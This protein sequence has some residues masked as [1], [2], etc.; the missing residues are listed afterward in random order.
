MRSLT[1]T[2]DTQTGDDGMAPATVTITENADGTLS[3]TITNLETPDDGQ[4]ADIRAL[5]FDVSDDALLGTMSATSSEVIISDFDDDGD[6]DNLGG[7]ATASG[8]PDSPYEVG[9]EF[10]TSGSAT[11]DYQTVSFTLDSSLRDL[12]LDDI[13]LETFVVRQTSVTSDS[14]GGREDSDK[15]YGDAPYP[16]NAIDDAEELDEDTTASGNV[17]ANDIDED[18]GDADNDGIPDGLTVTAIDG[19]S[20]AV[21]STITL[22][23]GITLVVNADG[24]Y[25]V[26]ANDAD[27]LSAGESVEFSVDYSVD[28]GNG[29]S[30]TATLT[31]TVN[32]VNDV[33]VVNSADGLG[34]VVEDDADPTLTDSG[35]IEFGDVDLLD[36]HTA[37]SSFDSTTHS[38]QLGSLTATLTGDTTG[39]GTGGEVT[40]DY[41]VSNAAVQFMAVGETITESY[42]VTISDGNGSTVTETVDVTITG[43]NDDVVITSADTSGAVVEDAADPV[44]SDGGTMSFA[45][46]DLSDGHDVTASFTSTDNVGGELGTFSVSETAD[47]TGTGTG[48]ALSWSFT[49]DNADVQFLGAGEVV[50]QTYTV[51]VTDNNGSTDTEVVTVTIAGVNDD[52]VAAIDVAELDEDTTLSGNVLDNDTDPDAKDTLTVSSVNG[53]G[54]GVG[55]TITLAAGITLVVAADGSYTVDANDA[56]YLSVGESLDFPVEYEVSDGNGGTSTA[57]LNITVNGVND[58]PVAEDDSNATDEDTPVSGSVLD[59]DSDIDRLDTLS[60]SAVNGDSGAVGS[61]IVLPSGAL[62]TLNADGTYD[63]DPNGAFDA[64][65]TGETGTDSFDYQIADGNGGFDTA[66]VTITIDGIDDVVPGGGDPVPDAVSIPECTL[67]T[68]NLFDNDPGST[69]GFSIAAINGDESL[70]GETM[71]LATGVTAVVNADGSFVVEGTDLG[72]LEGGEVFEDVLGY[73]VDNGAGETSDTT[74]NITI[75]GSAEDCGDGNFGTEVNEKGVDQAISNIVLYLSNDDGIIKVKIDEWNDGES[76]LDKYNLQAFLDEEYVDY[77]LIAVSIKSGNN[78]NQ[79]LGPGEGQLYLMDGD[80]D[81]DYEQGAGGLPEEGLTLDILGAKADDSWGFSAD[82]FG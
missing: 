25:T 61:E 6:V 45:D 65:N 24:S 22:D 57:T 23:D 21:G 16:V 56:D 19:D 40:W 44:L 29:G 78:H 58:A 1:F 35:I 39:S 59:N 5:F 20:G 66:T 4:I 9:I 14:E 10:G 37:S 8:T 77:D 71:T 73:T 17:F 52:P 50:T 18:A 27:Y 13:A 49:V 74:F 15:L 69:D 7:G 54:A 43:V 38:S 67:I 60:V 51:D 64:L 26:D 81:I 62:L 48:G 33:I 55:S 34:A 82:M 42:T 41:S 28:D 47:T 11:D 32:G 80:E 3:F 46:V 63:Y 68:G 2:L 31:I 79:D 12:T 75:T 36:S 72:W 70:V 53:S 30:D 76:D